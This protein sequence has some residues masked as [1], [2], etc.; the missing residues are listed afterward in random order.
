MKKGKAQIK[1]TTNDFRPQT[2]SLKK[3]KSNSGLMTGVAL[4][5]I[6]FVGFLIYSNSFDCSF[7]LDDRNSIIENLS[8][9]NLSDIGAIWNYNHSRFIPYL[10]FA[11]NYHYGEL[12]LWG[13]HF[14]NIVIHLI[15]AGLIWWLILLILSSPGLK[16]HQISE[17]K[18]WIAFFAA[19]LFVSH[20]LATQSV[21]YIVQRMAA[22]VAMFYFLSL[23][24]YIKARVTENNSILKYLL[25][26]GAVISAILALLTKENAFTLP[27]IIVLIEI[28]F[29]STNTSKIRFNYKRVIFLLTAIAIMA[30]IFSISFTG[31]ILKPIPASG[32][33]NFPVT[34][35]DYLLT[36]FSVIITYIRLLILPMNQNLDYDYPLAT[37]FFTLGTAFSF[38]IIVSLMGLAIYLFNKNRI[39]SFGI[40]WFF[41][42][43]V[44]E[45]SF[46]PIADLIFEHRTYL[47]SFGFFLIVSSLSYLFLRKNHK[48]ILLTLI[49]ILVATYSGMT[50]QRNK[51]WKDELT[52][53]SDVISKSPNKARP[54]L[55]RG[56]AYW[57]NNQRE[58][59]LADYSKAV[60]LNPKYFSHAYL[61]LGIA[62]ASFGNFEK[63][64]ISYTKTI[65]IDPSNLE[66]YSSRGIAY[67]GINEN[68]K[69]LLDFQ[70][71]IKLNPNYPKVYYNRGNIYMNKQQWESA[72]NDFT[73]AVEIDP[74]YIDAYSNRAIVYGNTG[75]LEKA[76]LDCSKV[77]ELDPNYVKAYNNRAITY[78]SLKKW[79]EAIADYSIVIQF[80]PKNKSVY[81]SRG[82]AY[83]N[84][85]N[86]ELAVAD[87]SKVMEI[88]PND[89]SANAS[90]QF[91]LSKLNTQSK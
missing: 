10:S 12:N 79:K 38:L 69:A 4:G 91:A 31:S 70:T 71:A 26:G 84:T 7:H 41:I 57:E 22:M 81:Y 53:W 9:R 90:R 11:I 73:K 66:A 18:K 24:L 39:V 27:F 67:A 72:I 76:I 83:T 87:F 25:F 15:N 54:Y 58:N 56:V 77:I 88:D 29:L 37:S 20:P 89:S 8:I 51:V 33:N 48:S 65:E 19:L 13:Y 32:G 45:S 59:A 60:E 14:I 85:E 61:N 42:T 55:N 68:E 62:D 46:I 23:T 35:T 43:L 5:I 63:A 3:T 47:P 82:V 86:W 80:A 50:F 49:I 21:T 78:C 16:N 17:H 44:V 34:S 75:A 2:S 52:L 28:F 64:I 30:V 6:F 40:F 1:L 74:R 36:Q